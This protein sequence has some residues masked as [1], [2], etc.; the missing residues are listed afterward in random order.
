MQAAIVD[1]TVS[2][3]ERTERDERVIQTAGLTNDKTSSLVGG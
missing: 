3:I 1:H 2:F